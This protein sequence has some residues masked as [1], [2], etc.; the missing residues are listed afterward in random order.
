MK[1]KNLGGFGSVTDPTKLSAR[2]TG[3]IIGSAGMIVWIVSY[4]TG[5]PQLLTPSDLEPVAKNIGD[6][7]GLAATAYGA[8]HTLFGFFRM[9]TV[10]YAEKQNATL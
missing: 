5:I 8:L 7:V 6:L 4:F 1:N 10:R 3:A 9:I 2:V